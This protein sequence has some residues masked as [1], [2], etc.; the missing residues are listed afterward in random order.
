MAN[1]LT[2]NIGLE[3]P[4][5]GD[6]D[7]DQPL[8]YNFDLLDSYLAINVALQVTPL[9]IGL[10]V[11]VNVG[12]AQIGPQVYVFPSTTTL[13]LLASTTNFI[14]VSNVG[15]LTSNNT[16]FPSVSVPLAKAFTG[17][18]NVIS[19]VDFR[20]FLGGPGGAVAAGVNTLAVT[21]SLIGLQGDIILDPGA[22]VTIT[23]DNFNNRFIFDV[24]G[25]SINRKYRQTVAGSLD[26]INMSFTTPD[27]FVGGSEEVFVDGILRNSGVVEDYVLIG[28]NGISFTFAPAMVS[29]ILV[30]YNPI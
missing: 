28:L 30:S 26:G 16:G 9:P 11:N 10:Q 19:V 21:G 15:A 4:A 25:G 18:A 3:K 6:Q 24:N 14:F 29:K 1:T 5:H 17:V 20:G 12:Q 2:P 23:Q 8:R 13:N 7:W 22:N 27:N